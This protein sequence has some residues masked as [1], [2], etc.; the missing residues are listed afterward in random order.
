MLLFRS[1]NIGILTY[2]YQ[3]PIGG[4]GAVAR[5]YVDLMKKRSPGDSFI[6]LSPSPGADD[7]LSWIARFRYKKPGGCPVFS[8]ALLWSLSSSLTRNHLS[9]LLVHSGSGGVFLLRKPVCRL[10]V[11]SHH[12]YQQEIDLVF[13]NQPIKKLWKR[14]MATFEKRTYRLADQIVCVSSDTA[15]SLINDY[16]ISRSKITVIENPIAQPPVQSSVLHSDKTLLFIGRLERRKGIE[17]LLEAFALI[18]QK[19]PHVRLRLIGTNLMGQ[20]LIKNVD[21]LG[22]TNKVTLL[23]SLEGSMVARERAEA[24]MLIVPSLLEGFGLVAAEGMIAGI[25]VIVSDC[26]GLKSLIKDGQTGLIFQSGEAE[27]LSNKIEQLLNDAELRTRLATQAQADARTR[28]NPE[29]RAQDL[30][31]VLHLS[32]G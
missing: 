4:L 16:G 21:H 13:Q 9:V 20:A 3:P 28:F 24:T 2:D 30:L 27:D 22:L 6:V 14:L 11:M 5:T 23:G 26:P 12:T 18:H 15:E 19:H 10:V 8:F 29:E 25:P 7:R 32:R 17:V 1:M 31:K